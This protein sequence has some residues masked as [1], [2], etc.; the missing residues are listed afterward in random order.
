MDPYL[1]PEAHA[2]AIYLCVQVH[3]PGDF[4][5]VFVSWKAEALYVVDAHISVEWVMSELW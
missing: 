2:N 5:T 3:Y 4:G 1:C